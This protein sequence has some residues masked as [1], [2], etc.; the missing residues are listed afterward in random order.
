LQIRDF[1]DESAVMGAVNSQIIKLI[2]L[3]PA[4]GESAQVYAI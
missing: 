2:L 3:Q 1:N 4:A